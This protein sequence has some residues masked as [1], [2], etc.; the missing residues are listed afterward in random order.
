[1]KPTRKRPRLRD[2]I[3]EH[4]DFHLTESRVAIAGHPLHAMLVAF[5][6]ALCVCTLGAD[7]MFWLTGDD[8]WPR[9]AIWAAAISFLMGVL[10]GIA[11]TVE[12]LAVPGIRIRAASWTHFIL[13]VMLLSILGA[14]WGIRWGDAAGAVLPWGILTSALAAGMTGITGWHGGKLVFDYGIGTQDDHGTAP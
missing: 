8:F 11:G 13:A 6:I 1:M 4:R 2:P 10:A 12:L 9:V 7:A 14:N 3:H 5:P